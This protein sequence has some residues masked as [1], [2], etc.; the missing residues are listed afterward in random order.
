MTSVEIISLIVTFIGVAS[1]AAV[2]TMLYLSF[3]NS[4]ILEIKTGKRDIELIDDVIYNKQEKVIRSKKRASVVKN[5]LFYIVMT[6]I[7]PIFV[8]S[9]INKFQGNTTMIGDS[10]VMVVASG[11]MSE[12]N[13]ANDYLEKNNLN[14]QFN[15]YDIIVLEKVPSYFSLKKYDVIAFKN[16]D[17]INV[18]HRIVDMTIENGEWVFITRGDS[19]NSNDK[20]HPKF[21]DVI[22]R[23]TNKKIGGIGIFIVFFQSAPGI[24][25]VIAM[26]YVL[27]MMDR[28]NNKMEKAQEE[29]IKHLDEVINHVGGD[30]DSTKQMKAIYNETIYYK[31]Y[32]YHFTDDGFVSKEE[33]VDEEFLEKSESTIIKVI[34]DENHVENVVEVDIKDLNKKSHI[35]LKEVDNVEIEGKEE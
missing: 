28:V 10:T 30:A 9:L 16:D 14:N 22:G 12:K 21:D 6:L 23:Y 26:V 33:I 1:F 29:R 31:G 27:T 7:I 5:T 15:T 32:A 4:S 11:S 25:T 2:F 19:N 17:G 34:E 8:F 20:Y 35:E 18:I 13:E 3:S 24:M